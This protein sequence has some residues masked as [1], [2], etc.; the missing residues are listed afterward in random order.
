MSMF[1]Y[2]KTIFGHFGTLK[3]YLRGSIQFDLIFIRSDFE[4]ILVLIPVIAL[5]SSSSIF[6]GFCCIFVLKSHH[7]QKMLGWF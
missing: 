7:Q 2:F 5:S 1:D 3:V 4:D 6:D